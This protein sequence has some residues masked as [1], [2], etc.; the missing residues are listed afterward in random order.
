MRRRI[1]PPIDWAAG[2]ERQ[3]GDDVA[4]GRHAS[5]EWPLSHVDLSVHAPS[6]GEERSGGS[7]TCALI[8]LSVAEGVKAIDDGVERPQPWP[9]AGGFRGDRDRPVPRPAVRDR[10]ARSQLQVR[11]N[12]ARD[13]GRRAVQAS[14]H[15]G[16]ASRRVRP[17][18]APQRGDQSWSP[19]L[20][21]VRVEVR[22]F[23]DATT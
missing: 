3:V 10:V 15:R 5:G 2:A 9:S 14:I 19:T 22:S 4:D 13:Q 6:T 7:G 1:A 21:Q 8:R 11:K 12:L 16:P 20:T 17:I 18:D 23:R